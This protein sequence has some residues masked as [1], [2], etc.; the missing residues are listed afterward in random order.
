MYGMG[1]KSRSRLMSST[2]KSANSLRCLTR[3]LLD[4]LFLSLPL[5]LRFHHTMIYLTI[6]FLLWVHSQTLCAQWTCHVLPVSLT[7]YPVP[8]ITC[9][10]LVY[11]YI[12]VPISRV[13]LTCTNMG[14]RLVSGYLFISCFSFC[15]VD[16][17]A[18]VSRLCLSSFI[19]TTRLHAYLSCLRLPVIVCRLVCLPVIYGLWLIYDSFPFYICLYLYLADHYIYGWGWGLVPHLQSTLQ[20]P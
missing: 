2:V 10:W 13:S 7:S 5:L 11:S 17:S 3:R 8:V 18:Y 20:P 19:L 15:L 6:V 16:S 9:H 4:R 12:S 14:W 1:W